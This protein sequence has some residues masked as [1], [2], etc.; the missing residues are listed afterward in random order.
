MD[1]IETI[2]SLPDL[3]ALKIEQI[4]RETL[5]TKQ[6]VWRWLRGYPVPPLKR[7]IIARILEKPESEL[8]PD[9]EK[10]NNPHNDD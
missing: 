6:T 7:P 1:F 8:W 9:D 4:A 2:S 3:K 10:L 5:S